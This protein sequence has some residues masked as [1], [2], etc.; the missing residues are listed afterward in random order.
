MTERGFEEEEEEERKGDFVWYTQAQIK[1]IHFQRALH[2][3]LESDSALPARWRRDYKNRKTCTQGSSTKLLVGRWQRGRMGGKGQCQLTS[4]GVAACK[5]LRA[6]HIPSYPVLRRQKKG[7]STA[8]LPVWK[9]PT[10][11]CSVQTQLLILGTD[12]AVPSQRT[13]E[14]PTCWLKTGRY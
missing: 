12:T 6:Q 2:S 9:V 7:Y 14:A 1:E 4:H 3:Y 11:T 8:R 13:R 10:D 5:F